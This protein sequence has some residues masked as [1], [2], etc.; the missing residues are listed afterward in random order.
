M[1]QEWWENVI[2]GWT[3]QQTCWISMHLLMLGFQLQLYAPAEYCM[4]YWYGFVCWE[5]L[6]HSSMCSFSWT[7]IYFTCRY[8]EH[9]ILTELHYKQLKEKKL[10]SSDASDLGSTSASLKA[11]WEH[12]ETFDAL[13]VSMSLYNV[14]ASVLSSS[15]EN[16][17]LGCIIWLFALLSI[18]SHGRHHFLCCYHHQSKRRRRTRRKDWWRAWTMSSI[19]HH[20]FCCYSAM[21]TYARPF[22][23]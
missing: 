4:V 11:T 14:I 6:R 8:L 2:M 9:I 12:T 23:G 16:R 7:I 21:W 18:G 10:T 20:E 22:H 1:W 15:K 19:W 5:S 3:A 17:I 13:G